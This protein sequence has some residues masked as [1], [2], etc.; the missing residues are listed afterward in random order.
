MKRNQL[1][2]RFKQEVC[3]QGIIVNNEVASIVHL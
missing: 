2:V 3:L 1:N